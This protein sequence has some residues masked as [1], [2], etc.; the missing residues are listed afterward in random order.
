MMLRCW[1]HACVY[2]DAVQ[3]KKLILL[4][5]LKPSQKERELRQLEME[6]TMLV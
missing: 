3:L 5:Y 1:L 4:G 6:V 2:V